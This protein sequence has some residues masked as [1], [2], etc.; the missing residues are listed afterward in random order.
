MPLDF[1]RLIIALSAILVVSACS[2]ARM[3]ANMVGDAMAGGG[4]VYASEEDP[5]LLMAALPF[6]L[7]TMESLIEISPR[8]ENLRLAA[9]RGFAAYAYVVQQIEA[10]QTGRSTAELRESDRR[11][12]RLFTRARDQALAGLEVRHPGFAD[13]LRADRDA[14]LARAGAADAELLYW[15]G[16]AW[17]GAISADKRDLAM[18]AELPT[19]ASLVT[20]TAELDDAF[21]GGAAHEF[22][23]LYEAGRPGGNLEGAEGHFRRALELSDGNSAGAHVGYAEVIA[24]ARQD[25]AAFREALAAALAIDPDAAPE[26]RLTN[27]L[28]Q[29]KAR[30]LL[31]ETERLILVA[32]GGTS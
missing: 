14:T 25:A 29:R 30:R 5:K 4:D 12:A 26:R 3:A 23:M 11:V 16:I 20:R 8:N 2:P 21:D 19:A 28:A 7:K 15:A 9:A 17:S 24:V 31:A 10:E 18:V 22:L 1:A 6:G 27:V 13:D 32:E